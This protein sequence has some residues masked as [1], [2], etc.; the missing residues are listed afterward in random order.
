M[1]I[2]AGS[3]T[4]NMASQRGGN[5]IGLNWGD[6]IHAHTLMAQDIGSHPTIAA[7]IAKTDQNEDSIGIKL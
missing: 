5:L 1:H 6:D 2:T 4:S 7:I 3:T